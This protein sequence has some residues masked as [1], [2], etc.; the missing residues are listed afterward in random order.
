MSLPAMDWCSHH[1]VCGFVSHAGLI[2]SLQAMQSLAGVW[3]LDRYA[4]SSEYEI[5]NMNQCNKARDNWFLG[6]FSADSKSIGPTKFKITL[7][8]LFLI[9]AWGVLQESNKVDSYMRISWG[10][11]ST[12]VPWVPHYSSNLHWIKAAPHT[13]LRS[14]WSSLSIC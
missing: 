3:D 14:L 9:Q 12:R 11:A 8:I 5:S 2:M 4:M 6:P 1:I 7:V 10:L 13:P